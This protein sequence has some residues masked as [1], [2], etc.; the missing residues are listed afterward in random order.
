MND[1]ISMEGIGTTW[2]APAGGSVLGV[3]A[4]P[5]AIRSEYGIQFHDQAAVVMVYDN[6]NAA[7]RTL[8]HQRADLKR[9][10]IP[11]EY[12]PMLVQRTVETAVSNWFH[13]GE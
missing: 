6:E 12:W 8:Q 2:P 3:G 13:P 7:M 5:A 10:G 1:F 9:M 4:R 11:P